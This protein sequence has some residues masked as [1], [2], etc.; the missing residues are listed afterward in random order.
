MAGARRRRPAFGALWSPAWAALAL[1]GA[2]AGG[3]AVTPRGP[4]DPVCT[5][6][7]RLAAT[8]ELVQC[9]RLYEAMVGETLTPSASP[10]GQPTLTPSASPTGVPTTAS[11]LIPAP[12]TPAPSA[13]PTRY[14]WTW[15]PSPTPAPIRGKEVDISGLCARIRDKVLPN[16]APCRASLA[17]AQCAP[18]TCAEASI[19]TNVMLAAIGESAAATG[20]SEASAWGPHPMCPSEMLSCPG[21]AVA[22]PN[23]KCLRERNTTFGLD[24]DKNPVFSQ[25]SSAAEYSTSYAVEA[26]NR[27]GEQVTGSIGILPV[28]LWTNQSS[29]MAANCTARGLA[30]YYYTQAL[31]SLETQDCALPC[32]DMVAVHM[33]ASG[34]Q[35]KRED[36]PVCVTNANNR[37]GAIVLGTLSVLVPV[38]VA[39]FW[40]VASKP[41]EA[42][43]ERRERGVGKNARRLNVLALAGMALAVFVFVEVVLGIVYAAAPGALLRDLSQAAALNGFLYIALPVLLLTVLFYHVSAWYLRRKARYARVQGGGP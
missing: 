31:S 14:E 1:C 5:S 22:E 18:Q 11:P 38:A 30:V 33:L 9:M 35:C 39:I 27:A 15:T 12:S 6:D 43:L 21:G 3:G 7:E 19:M 41:F 40:A 37:S 25:T 23:V 32:Q 17:S 28:P 34:F 10:T 8:L 29:L 4:F 2:L 36:F 20:A 16:F 42:W 13:S 24:T 26:M